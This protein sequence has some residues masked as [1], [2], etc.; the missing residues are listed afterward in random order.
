M[1]IHFFITALIL[2][3][4]G[5]VSAITETKIIKPGSI[6]TALRFSKTECR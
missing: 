5:G 6:L 4:G 2:F 1:K 3:I